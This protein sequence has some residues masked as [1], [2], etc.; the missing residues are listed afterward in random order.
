MR[1]EGMTQPFINKWSSKLASLR[2]LVRI[3]GLKDKTGAG[4]LNLVQSVAESADSA[5]PQKKGLGK[6]VIPVSESDLLGGIE[7]KRIQE[8]LPGMGVGQIDLVNSKTSSRLEQL[9]N[10]LNAILF[11]GYQDIDGKVIVKPPLFNLDVTNIK[12][13]KNLSSSKDPRLCVENNPFVIY[14]AEVESENEMEDET[15]IVATRMTVQGVLTPGFQF[16]MAANIKSVASFIDIPLLSRFGIRESSPRTIHF[17]G[18]N[19][20]LLYA[21]AASE[22]RK[23]NKGFRTYNCTIP[24]RPEI[25]LGFPVY[26]AHH[27]MYAYPETISISYNVGGK[28]TMTLSCD[29]LRKRPMVGQK[30]EVPD[31]KDPS[32][33]RKL[34]VY[35]SKPTIALSLY[36][37]R[38]N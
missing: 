38:S 9:R 11:E 33:K 26:I 19:S 10:M 2:K 1:K 20:N 4:Y 23:A 24:L 37:L 35:E 13:P 28:A 36:D 31:E 22:L 27:D 8:Y 7:L 34:T 3:F 16:D 21:F 30:I 14:P 29:T 18:N 17:L 25:K 32:K 12:V 6:K 5:D 15:R